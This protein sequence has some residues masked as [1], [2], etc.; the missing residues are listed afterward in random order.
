M[1][2]ISNQ[3]KIIFFI[4]DFKDF[5]IWGIYRDT[6]F[7]EF[8]EPEIKDYDNNIEIA[9]SEI[10]A[11]FF[12]YEH[13]VVSRIF[14]NPI[15]YEEIKSREFNNIEEMKELI[16]FICTDKVTIERKY[17]LLSQIAFYFENNNDL[18]KDIKELKECR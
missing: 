1:E 14:Y 2:F 10:C 6:G 15:T 9:K 8:Y 3:C 7:S 13:N 11:I 16:I 12:K 4:K 5:P 18:L 17:Q